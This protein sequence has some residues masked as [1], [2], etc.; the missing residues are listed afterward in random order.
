MSQRAA[1]PP[2]AG[3]SR[4]KRGLRAA[5]D[6]GPAADRLQSELE[7]LGLGPY[8]ARALLALM[9]LG[10]ATV[11]ELFPVAG[12]PR[13]SAYPALEMLAR[14]G[15]AA[16]IP[17]AGMAVW[18]A[19]SQELIFQRLQA[20]LE[21]SMSERLA[22]HQERA[23]RVREL[24]AETLEDA[25]SAALPHIQLLHGPNEMKAAYERLLT[26][27]TSHFVMFT[28]P[29]YAW[30]MPTPNDVVLATLGRG[31]RSRVL[32]QAAEWNDPTA[33]AFRQEMNAY[34]RAGVEARLALDLPIKLVVV[35]DSR[36][37]VAMPDS[38]A[39]ELTYPMTMLIEHP[40]YA[41]IQ[42]AAFERLWADAEPVPAV[43]AAPES[44]EAGGVGVA[45]IAQDS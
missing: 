37:L 24:L 38:G 12:I 40:G 20:S 6:P 3:L 32:Y 23:S 44:T 21:H 8:E 35:D 43:S 28:R 26:E 30:S 4:R 13:T 27:A 9:R 7:E 16:R 2:A 14:K 36:T 10:Q 42:V 17:A 34:H 41:R 11:A 1:R 45:E 25:S 39:P 31:I 15:L 5:P 18:S 29:P 22:R 19:P 33:E